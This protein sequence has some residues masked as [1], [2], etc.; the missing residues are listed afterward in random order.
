[1]SN[2]KNV[3]VVGIALAM[4]V[5][6]SSAGFMQ[7]A[8]AEYIANAK[9]VTTLKNQPVVF[10]VTGSAP[11]EFFYQIIQ[12]TFNG[13]VVIDGATGEVKYKPNADFIG[14]DSFTFRTAA[15]ANPTWFGEQAMVTINVLAS[16]PNDNGS[17]T[18]PEQNQG[19]SNNNSNQNVNVGGSGGIS[20]SGGGLSI[21]K[22]FY[23]PIYNEL[24]NYTGTTIQSASEPFDYWHNG[25]R[26][27]IEYAHFDEL[28]RRQADLGM[29]G[30]T[31]NQ[32]AWLFM[33]I[34]PAIDAK[35][36]WIPA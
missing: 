28:V 11:Q 13:E 30:L 1:M 31:E 2:A 24:K 8:Y 5:L 32:K 7:T 36:N 33:Q 35:F 9:T 29:Q 26:T 14:T 20:K 12:P 4:A 27:Y 3:M 17:H 15:V 16:N 18:S 22:M 34:K 19:N 25:T 6:F 10:L 21:W 23:E